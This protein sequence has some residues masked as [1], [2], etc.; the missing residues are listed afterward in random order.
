LYAGGHAGCQPHVPRVRQLD[1][2]DLKEER[3][4]LQREVFPKLRA[5]CDLRTNLCVATFHREASASAAPNRMVACGE[6]G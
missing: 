5:L 1:V 6:G 3:N 4:A 2:R